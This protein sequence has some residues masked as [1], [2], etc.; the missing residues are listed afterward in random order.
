MARLVLVG[1]ESKRAA[2]CRRLVA[3]LILSVMLPQRV[4]HEI[5]KGEA[6]D[7]DLGLFTS[8]QCYRQEPVERC[9]LGKGWDG[10]MYLY[11]AVGGMHNII[12]HPVTGGSRLEQVTGLGGKQERRSLYA[13][14]HA[15]GMDLNQIKYYNYF[16]SYGLELITSH[17][18]SGGED[19]RQDG[20][21]KR[22]RHSFF[23]HFA[24]REREGMRELS[25]RL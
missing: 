13:R 7:G 12:D 1:F 6:V 5:E 10:S 24:M 3:A 16:T 22:K 15:R 18:A 2:E 11:P 25:L 21:G 9:S 20:V 4:S 14:V 23:P 19:K 17:I 8:R